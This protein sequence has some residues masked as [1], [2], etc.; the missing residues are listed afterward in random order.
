MNLLNKKYPIS[1]AETQEIVGY[2]TITKCVGFSNVA[3]VYVVL[4][5]QEDS[6]LF[7]SYVKAWEIEKDQDNIPDN[8]LD[9]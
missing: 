5:N 9:K 7:L 1:N 2:R 6:P 3:G 4:N 8:C